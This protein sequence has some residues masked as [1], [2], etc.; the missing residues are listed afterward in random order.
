MKY[1]YP[2]AFKSK[3]IGGKSLSILTAPANYNPI[4]KTGLVTLRIGKWFRAKNLL[5][6]SSQFDYSKEVNRDGEPIY[7]VGQIVF[8]PFDAITY[9][10]FVNYFSV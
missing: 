1:L 7:A 3:S 2:N 6:Q 10:E 4:K 9:D 8:T 5:I